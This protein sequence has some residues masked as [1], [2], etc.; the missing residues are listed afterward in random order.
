MTASHRCPQCDAEIPPSSPAGLCPRCLLLAANESQ[1]V[2]VCEPGPT[3]ITPPESGFTPPTPEELAPLFPQLEIQ[4]LL[5]KGGMGA[6]Y[7][8]RQ[9]GLDRVVAVKILPSEISHD[10]KFIERFQREARALAKLNHPHIVTVYDFGQTGGLCYIVMEF[11]DGANLRQVIRKQTLTAA[12][13]LKIVPQICEALQ[14]AHDEGV[15][16]RDIKPENVLID[17]RGRVK[18]ADFGLAKLLGPE[19][20]DQ[21][22]TATQ[23]VM[24]TLRYM[25]PEQ[26]QGARAVD[27]RADIYSLGVVFY[28]LLTGELPM[29][30]FAPPS[31]K[32]EIDVR[33]DEVVLR[34]LEQEPEQR[35]QHASDVKTDIESIS[36]DSHGRTAGSASGSGE[37][38]SEEGLS[39][40]VERELRGAW[41]WVAGE[42]A[43]P[44]QPPAFPGRFMIVLSLAGCLMLMLPWLELH[45]DQ[46]ADLKQF[47]N[48]A[49]MPGP[50]SRTLYGSE[51]LPGIV[52]GVAFGL[53][54]LLLIMTPGGRPLTG[55]RAAVMSIIA[56]CAVVPSF[57]IKR[58][59][60]RK[61]F[62]IP[63]VQLKDARFS[64]LTGASDGDMQ[65]VGEPRMQREIVKASVLLK[66]IEYQIKYREGFYGSL[67]LSVTLLVL[68]S[69]GVRHAVAWGDERKAVTDPRSLPLDGLPQIRRQ[70]L[71]PAIALMLYGLL[72][73][74]PVVLIFFNGLDIADGN[75]GTPAPVGFAMIAFSVLLVGIAGVVL[76]GGWHL[77]AVENYRAAWLGSFLAQPV[78]LWGL[79]VLSR[80]EVK[81]AFPTPALAESHEPRLSQHA[82]WGA[83][84]AG[85][86]LIAIAIFVLGF[87]MT[88]VDQVTMTSVDDGVS[89]IPAPQPAEVPEQIVILLIPI[90]LLCLLSVS[91]PIG[92]TILGVIATGHIK[93][94]NGK[95]YG[96]RLAFVDVLFY[97]L[98]L[99]GITTFVLTHL[100][101]IVIWN[102]VQTGSIRWSIIS[103]GG[104]ERP[105][106]M[107]LILDALV[108][109]IV[110]YFVAV[111]AW[112]KITGTQNSTEKSPRPVPAF[113]GTPLTQIRFTVSDAQDVTR[114]AIFHFS[115]LGY[116]LI[117]QHPDVCVFQRGSK[118]AGLWE[119]DIRG[120]HTQLTVR[121]TP[122]NAGMVWVSC[123]WSVRTW[124]G[125]ITR[126]DLA[127]L[128]AEGRGL[129]SLI[130]G[131][132]AT[133]TGPAIGPDGVE[134]PA[135]SVPR[136]RLVPF[137]ATL[138]LAAAVILLL[139]TATDQPTTIADSVPRLWRVW[140]SIDVVLGF[141][142]AAGLFAASIGLFLWKPWARRVTLAVCVF[143]LASFVFDAPYLAR[144][145]LPEF[146]AE[147]QS[148]SAA[149]GVAPEMQE[150]GAMSTVVGFL[151][152]P[153]VLGL[154]WLIG[155]LIYFTRPQVVAAL[156]SPNENPSQ[157][158]EWMFS[159]TGAAVGVFSVFGPL[160]L[161]L[162]LF[163]LFEKPATPSVVTT[164]SVPPLGTITSG[165]GAEFTVPAGQVA[166]FEVVTRRDNE[167]VPVPEHCGYVMAPPD[168][169]VKGSFRWSRMSPDATDDNVQNWS[170]E[171]LTAGVGRGYTEAALLPEELNKSVGAMSLGLGVLTPNEEVI[172]WGS[173]DVNN[174]PANGLIG[175]RVTVVPH[176]MNS[177]ASGN[178][179]IDWK[180]SQSAQSTSRR[181]LPV[182]VP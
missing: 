90:F 40:I 7:K 162:G 97:P 109:V 76:R 154:V 11:V 12:E 132:T 86:G 113:V 17:K 122:A 104:S 46:D 168:K 146:Y 129:E 85:G 111:S 145:V 167:T 153:T 63:I 39:T 144:F 42:A 138:N 64:G 166:T 182:A 120:L 66:T 54:A 170:L 134:A 141:L 139:V 49:E 117:E 118:W 3:R 163:A 102:M 55:R 71:G 6:V 69:I 87:I 80:P 115:T 1:S 135:N 169:D 33:L 143:G 29:G 165:I 140:E 164:D 149:E 70:L 51:R 147:V 178:A 96:L 95:L 176:G 58:D 114:Q 62:T 131:H 121:T 159:G 125:W 27:H 100:L 20:S 37:R 50:F 32:V 171:I 56:A 75:D 38:H 13:A 174:L 57:L 93:R 116:Q 15:V 106:A 79:F 19:G 133:D 127:K 81:A 136:P 8:A 82:L 151:V 177:A 179:H 10:P 107:F 83:I 94:S 158:V 123:D 108:M 175:L 103:S 35:Y 156:T 142:L 31:K 36:A 30:K 150:L 59:L 92:T 101:Q 68:S 91:A 47:W 41:H 52:A 73:F 155:Q 130:H 21:S 160:L 173:A 128:E 61:G 43:S 152:V 44:T 148:T 124:G 24:G 105:D 16:H 78:G 45:I 72:I 60:E 5:G 25:A 77:L 65:V 67:V 126:R 89:M 119:M 180:R 9:P 84:W 18:I 112:R 34:A 14:F 53:L 22:L 110:C 157:L 161:L 48:N 98:S 2:E 181:K 172:H 88:S 4:E 99:L 137:I 28:E 74:G 26:M 23:Q